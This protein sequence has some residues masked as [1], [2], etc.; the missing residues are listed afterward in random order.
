MRRSVQS[1]LQIRQTTRPV[2]WRVLAIVLTGCILLLAVG[3]HLTPQPSEGA[4]SRHPSSSSRIP[5]SA[6]ETTATNHAAENLSTSLHRD[7]QPARAQ[8]GWPSPND[9]P[10]S[11]RPVAGLNRLP[12]VAH[13]EPASRHA[14]LAA[15]EAF[16]TPRGT[17]QLRLP[18]PNQ[19]NGRIELD[20][21]D[22]V[23]SVSVRD[24][25]LRDLL[26][27][28]AESQ[29][30]NIISSQDVDATITGSFS[31]A[32]FVDVME[33]IFSVTGYTW[34]RRNNTIL[35]T[36]IDGESTL[37]PEAQGRE[38]RVFPLNYVSAADIQ[39][40]IT[41]LLSPAGKIVITE[42]NI[43]DTH[44]TRELVII[45]EIPQYL[46]RV[47]DYISRIDLPPRQVLIEA[48]I[49]EVDLKDDTAHGIDFAE[50]SKVGGADLLLSSPSF[51][52]T[53]STLTSFSS[54]AYNIGI[55][56]SGNLAGLIEALTKTTDAKTLASPRVL[57]LN[58]QESY[59]Q[60]G[61]KLGYFVTTTTETS[62][63][64]SVEFIDTGVVL[65]VTPYI[66]DDDFIMM[67]VKPEVSDGAVD[68][69][70]LPSERT[71]EVDTT[72]MLANGTGMVIG[73]LIK[74]T[75]V[76][77]DHKI[78]I[79]GSLWMIGKMFRRTSVLRERSEI[80]IALVPH[81]VASP[82]TQLSPDK[83]ERA[84][85]PLFYGPLQEFPRP[86]EP[87]FPGDIGR[88]NRDSGKRGG[89]GT[90]GLRKTITRT[91]DDSFSAAS[92]FFGPPAAS[93][94]LRQPRVGDGHLPE[95]A[96]E[97][98]PE[99]QPLRQPQ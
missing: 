32:S 36:P 7:G 40:I 60:I 84:T 5:T 8:F 49:L 87:E 70:G 78:P 11:L 76:E 94:P 54:P 79:L 6:L 65:K 82:H 31:E 30:L 97:S 47:A 12:S 71:T 45:E 85:T 67:S 15:F 3:T 73:G 96:F 88:P 52:N 4:A 55:L 43:A 62:T 9:E 13:A 61:E 48:H 29:G 74:E 23:I 37:P 59:V 26:A 33:A 56:N 34:V 72:I 14:Q 19:Q 27:V 10:F 80:I 95:P 24:A 92:E 28:L 46:E 51:N 22:G 75:I 21:R 86:W 66:T 44:Q 68:T 53:M 77:E 58:G 83:L 90:N 64:Q 99:V 57:A 89:K 38:V 93:P 81:I 39:S 41:P 16:D 2:D 69:L 98:L 17:N 18:P 42:T 20:N 91:F 63:Q 1:P 25:P 35:V 50:L